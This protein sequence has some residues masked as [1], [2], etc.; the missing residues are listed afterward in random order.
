MFF[1]QGEKTINLM[2]E[3]GRLRKTRE[4]AGMW[5]ATPSQGDIQNYRELMGG[6]FSGTFIVANGRLGDKTGDHIYL[7]GCFSSSGIE[8]E[9]A[10]RKKGDEY[11]IESMRAL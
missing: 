5:Y 7:E 3:Y 2:M 8:V 6:D 4:I 10:L 11:L 9:I 1:D